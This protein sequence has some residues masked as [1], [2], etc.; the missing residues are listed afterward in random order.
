MHIDEQKGSDSIS[1]SIQGRGAM[2]NKLAK[3]LLR[4]SDEM[5]EKKSAYFAKTMK[6]H[7]EDMREANI[8][9]YDMPYQITK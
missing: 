2:M 8:G 4:G 7:Y 6:K 5:V 9:F 1:K 3:R